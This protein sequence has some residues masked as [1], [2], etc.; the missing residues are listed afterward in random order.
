MELCGWV[1]RLEAA[2]V[3]ILEGSRN[4]GGGDLQAGLN[5]V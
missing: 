4:A 2:P 1:R 3:A 5:A